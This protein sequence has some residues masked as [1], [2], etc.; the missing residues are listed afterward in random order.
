MKYNQTVEYAINNKIIESGDIFVYEDLPNERFY[1]EVY[2]FCSKNL[3]IQQVDG[4]LSTSLFLYYNYYSKNANAGIK[5]EHNVILINIGLMRNCFERFLYNVEL[6]DY[7][8]RKWK[9]ITD[10]FNTSVS[11]LAFQ[12][13]THFTYYHELAHLFQMSNKRSEIGLQERGSDGIYNIIQHKLEI[14]ADTF[15]AICI[16]TQ[17]QQYI[18]TCFAEIDQYIVT[19]TITIFS[20][21]LLEHIIC[22]SDSFKL[23]YDEK[24]H[25]HSVIRMFNI[26]LNLTNHLSSNPKYIKKGIN[27]EIN[28][29]FRKILDFHAELE[30]NGIFTSGFSDFVN[31]KM[32]DNDRILKHFK[33]IKELDK[34]DGYID[35]MD[36]WNSRV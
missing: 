30:K 3:E 9:K 35:A 4:L 12:I 6:N 7:T 8:E 28:F 32:L 21:C 5:K 27:I 31:S 36:V 34:S 25:P 15:A 24:S 13:N 17:I 11:H 16:A 19:N 20:A 14:N 2:N 10:S 33:E 22:F 23:Y 1:E 26:I 18:E 29:L